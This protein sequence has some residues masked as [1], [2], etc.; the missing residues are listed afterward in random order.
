MKKIWAILTTWLFL[1]S[2]NAQQLNPVKLNTP[3]KNRGTAIMKALSDRKSATEY[4]DKMLSHEDLS[5][6]FW[7]AN[8]IN[9]PAESKKTAASAMNRQD[10]MIYAFTTEGVYLYDAEAHE[11]KPVKAGDHRKLC[12]ERGMSPLIVLLVSDVSKFGETGTLEL[13]KEWG[14]IDVGLVS[15]NI[16][17]FCS[18]NGIGTRPRAS[19]NREE[20]KTLLGLTDTQLPMLNHSVGYTK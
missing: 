5:D 2:L 11:L 18:G 12:G 7:A 20:I 14:A 6:L 3:N 15:Q 17:L 9:R 13:R 16:A 1:F 10:V 8:G 4:T 19:M